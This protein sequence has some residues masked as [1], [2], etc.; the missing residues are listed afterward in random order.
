MQSHFFWLFAVAVCRVLFFGGFC[1][2]RSDI[3]CCLRCRVIFFWLFLRIAIWYFRLMQ[4]HSF[5]LFA[6]CRVLFLVVFVSLRDQMK[7]NMRNLRCCVFFALQSNIPFG[8]EMTY[9]FWQFWNIFFIDT[10]N[11]HKLFWEQFGSNSVRDNST[12][13]SRSTHSVMCSFQAIKTGSISTMTWCKPRILDSRGHQEPSKK[14]ETQPGPGAYYGLGRPV[15][16]VFKRCHCWSQGWL[17]PFQRQNPMLQAPGARLWKLVLGYTPFMC[18]SLF[19]RLFFLAPKM[20][21]AREWSGN[22]GILFLSQSIQLYP[23]T[24]EKNL[25]ESSYVTS[26]LWYSILESPIIMSH[27]IPLYIYIHMYK[28]PMKSHEISSYV[29]T[30]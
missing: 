12:I 20:G 22:W 11:E 30:I 24:P 4:S 5:W 9:S 13:I 7:K 25:W 26:Q 1:G 15:F 19:A 29:A 2:L 6:V 16:A 27:C 8:F 17:Q 18:L 21:F 14:E 28:Y 10:L 3:F 23:K